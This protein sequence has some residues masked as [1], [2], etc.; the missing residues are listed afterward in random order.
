[1]TYL[2]NIAKK[3]IYCSVV[4][5]AAAKEYYNALDV[6]LNKLDVDN[7]DLLLE[8]LNVIVDYSNLFA[9][10]KTGEFFE[11]W[12]RVIPTNFTYS[13]AGYVAGLNS[14]D[15]DFKYN[16][17]YEK[18][19]S[20]YCKEDDTYT[21]F[22]NISKGLYDSSTDDKEIQLQ[23][24]SNLLDNMYWYDKELFNT[25]FKGGYT[26]DKL[27]EKTGISRMSIFNTIK[28]VKKYLRENI[29]EEADKITDSK[30]LY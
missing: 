3:T 1:M 20:N 14:K 18:I 17:Y 28:K 21:S 27:S 12:I 5:E 19:D 29:N 6:S 26:L 11:E 10:D 30:D 2:F 25:Y 24:V 16:K 22:D 9:E 4:H 13:L 7:I 15:F 8:V 23:A